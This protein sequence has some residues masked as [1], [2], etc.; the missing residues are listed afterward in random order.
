MKA[1]GIILALFLG[2]LAPSPA[3]PGQQAGKVPLLGYLDGASAST[4]GDNLN[5][6]RQGLR[7]LGWIEGQNIAIEYRWAEGRFDRLPELA[8][9]LVRLRVDA[10]VATGDPVIL[11]AKQATG[12]IPIVMTAVGDPIGAGFVASLARP[13][14]NVTGVSNLA[15]DLTGKW[16]EL[17]KE[18]VPKVSQVAI[19]RNVA[20][21]THA[22]FWQ[23]AQTAAQKLR[24]KVHSVEVR[25]SHDLDG[26]FAAM[27]QKRVGAVVV[28]PDP[29]LSGERGRIA[30]LAAKSRLP[31]IYTFRGQ[32][33]A[34]G[35]MS[36]GPSLQANFR[37]AATFVDKILK[38]AKPADLPVEQPTR[39]EMVVNMKTAKALGLT[40]PQSILV[41]ADQVIQ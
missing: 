39:F 40:I 32:A 13:G 19:L 26:A 6:F 24:V 33:E 29:L 10:I 4:S 7:E 34:G 5:A 12:T 36:Y 35:L 16:L 41:R 18:V 2:A 15:V 11:A 20:N 3:S 23:E 30:D 22:L 9:D 28:L 14:G 37:R 21:R 31:A 27:A 1:M 38:G 17:L 8:A 25:S